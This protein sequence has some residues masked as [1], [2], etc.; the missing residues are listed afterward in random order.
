MFLKQDCHMTLPVAG[1]HHYNSTT[2][3]TKHN[4]MLKI[5]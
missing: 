5:T 4:T 3:Y 2:V 1:V